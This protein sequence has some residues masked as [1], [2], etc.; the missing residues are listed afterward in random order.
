MAPTMAGEAEA[1]DIQA[2][3]GPSHEEISR[4]AYSFWEGRGGAG[5]SAEEDWFRAESELRQDSR[6]T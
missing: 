1:Q 2:Q 5:G 3:P 4:L 6:F